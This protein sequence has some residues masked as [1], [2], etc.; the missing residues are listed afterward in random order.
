MKEITLRDTIKKSIAPHDSHLNLVHFFFS[1]AII[2]FEKIKNLICFDKSIF[3]EISITFLCCFF[4]FLTFFPLF[5]R[6][7]SYRW[8]FYEIATIFIRFYSNSIVVFALAEDTHSY[9]VNNKDSLLSS[10][11]HLM[12]F[13]CILQML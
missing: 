7:P 8:E 10:S 9:L 3:I 4:K 1:V 11:V 12:V 2:L 5:N 13:F 6:Q